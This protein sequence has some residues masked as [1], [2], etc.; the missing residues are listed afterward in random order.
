MVYT[1]EV[2]ANFPRKILIEGDGRNGDGGR[3]L[4]R[5]APEAKRALTW[6]KKIAM[7]NFIYRRLFWQILAK[8]ENYGN[9][10]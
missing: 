6:Q 10:K 9:F 8:R 1:I 2:K 3:Y 4:S 5:R 7:D